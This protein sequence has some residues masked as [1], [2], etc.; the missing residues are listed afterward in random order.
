MSKADAI[1]AKA[2]RQITREVARPTGAGDQ[3]VSKVRRTVDLSPERHRAL[4]RLCEDAAV[5]RG[6]ARVNSQDMLATAIAHLL[7]DPEMQR[8]VID[9]LPAPRR[10]GSAD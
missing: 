2:T 1:R 10:R 6:W 8:Q 7:D 3:L 9:K 5:A 4:N